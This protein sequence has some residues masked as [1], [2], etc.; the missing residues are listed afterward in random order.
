MKWS[1]RDESGHAWV[2]EVVW[3]PSAPNPL[4]PFAVSSFMF[5]P[6]AR[7]VR[8]VFPT[9]SG[10]SYRVRVSKNLDDWSVIPSAASESETPVDTRHYGTGETLT[11]YAEAPDPFGFYQVIAD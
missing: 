3:T 4:G 10:H 5:D 6:S 11:L 9:V 1:E 8:L 7:L 2:A